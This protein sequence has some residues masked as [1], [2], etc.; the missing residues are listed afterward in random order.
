MLVMLVE[1]AHLY[2][3]A[4]M[5]QED[6]GFP[7]VLSKDKVN[8]FEYIQGPEGDVADIADRRGNQDKLCHKV[9]TFS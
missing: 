1:R 4:V 9:K 7:C 6:T 5:L 2:P 8:S 3:D